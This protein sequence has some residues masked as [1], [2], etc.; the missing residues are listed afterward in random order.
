MHRQ[1]SDQRHGLYLQS[2][3][4]QCEWNWTG[5]CSIFSAD[6]ECADWNPECSAARLGFTSNWSSHRFV[7]NSRCKWRPSHYGLHHHRIWPNR[8]CSWTLHHWWIAFL[9]GLW[10]AKWHGLHVLGVC[11]QRQWSRTS[12]AFYRAHD[13]THASNRP[14]LGEDERRKRPSCRFLECP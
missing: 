6:P 7:V 13:P 3:R 1:W 10:P 2:C 14:N 8:R 11:H 9:R 12:I 4:L 5:V